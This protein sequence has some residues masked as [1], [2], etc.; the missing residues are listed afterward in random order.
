MEFD[1]Y[2]IYRLDGNWIDKEQA[3]GLA[4]IALQHQKVTEAKAVAIR[5]SK[6]IS[7]E[8]RMRFGRKI[9]GG[10]REEIAVG[11]AKQLLK[12][13]FIKFQEEEDSLMVTLTGELYTI[14]DLPKEKERWFE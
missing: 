13:G 6:S 12:D 1:R 10:S 8:D 5:A 14:K 11:I 2:I 7:K 9:T 3:K 4:Q